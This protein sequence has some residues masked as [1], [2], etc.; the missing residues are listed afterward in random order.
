M[1]FGL[2]GRDGSKDVQNVDGGG[3]RPMLRGNFVV[4]YGAAPCNQWGICGIVVRK[5]E[6]I[7]LPCGLVNWVELKHLLVG[8][9]H[10][11]GV[12]MHIYYLSL[13]HI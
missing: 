1:S 13:I 3:D 6:A 10:F 2:V 8:N 9:G 5:R 4:G 7:E 11:W 12:F